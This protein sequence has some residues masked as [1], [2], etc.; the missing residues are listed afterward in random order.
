V[1]AL[2]PGQSVA[3]TFTSAVQPTLAGTYYTDVTVDYGNTIPEVDET[4][5]QSP[6][7]PIAVSDT[8]TALPDITF[9]GAPSVSATTV[10]Q[11]AALSASYQVMNVGTAST[12][13]A[14][15]SVGMYF[16]TDPTVTTAD[17]LMC[18]GKIG[19][20][21]PTQW[22][23]SGTTCNVMIAPGVYY[24]SIILDD[25]SQVAEPNEANNVSTPIQ[26]TVN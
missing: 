24:M 10:A 2:N 21:G 8:G 19:P 7:V 23:I 26:I 12:G 13:T 11:G 17:T 25:Q 4:N 6:L 20:L 3:V 14:A 9:S 18:A 5:N 1:P 15:F 16:S 22:T